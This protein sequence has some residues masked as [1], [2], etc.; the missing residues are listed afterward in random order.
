MNR[1]Y[2]G[3]ARRAA[4]IFVSSVLLSPAFVS[5]GLAADSQ[6]PTA[7]P[8]T[9]FASGQDVQPY[10]E[11]WIKN[12][13]GSFDMVFGYF[14]RNYQ[15]EVAIPVGADNMVE[16]GAPDRG[17]PTFFYPRITRSALKVVVPKDWGPKTELTWT[18]TVRGKTEKAV[19][20][21]QPEWEIDPIRGGS[22]PNAEALAD[23]PLLL[24]PTLGETGQVQDAYLAATAEELA[25]AYEFS[26]PAWT[27]SE[28]RKLHRPWF[29][30]PLAAVRAVLL[31]ES[32][33]AFR[34]RNL[35]ISENAL[36][37]A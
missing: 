18:L 23:T 20:W 27:A 22:T 7:I 29:A 9:K 17:Q 34:A 8:Q 5:W 24:A 32:P 11:G 31:L 33:P 14:N 10:F 25:R 13:D 28:A 12:R 6:L 15:E 30:S 2:R 19:A 16:P 21:L 36:S 4:V 1:G 3:L 35:F 37:R 26:L